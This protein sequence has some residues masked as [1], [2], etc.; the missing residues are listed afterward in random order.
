MAVKKNSFP[1]NL[2]AASALLAA[3]VLAMVLAG[4]LPAVRGADNDQDKTK[5][6]TEASGETTQVTLTPEAVKR[7]GIALGRAK[8]QKLISHIIAPA[9]V[10]F[11]TN[12]MAVVGCPVQGRVT[13]LKVSVG[14]TVKKG[15]ELLIVESPELGEA[16]SDYLQK[17]TGVVAATATVDPLKAALDRANALYVT[18]GITLTEVQKRDLDYKTAQNA[19]LTAKAAVKAAESRLKLLGMDKEAVARLEETGEITPQFTVRAPLDGTVTERLVT[20]GELVK[21]DREKLLVVADMTTLWVIADVPEARI[22]EVKSGEKVSIAI[23]DQSFDG[24]VSKVGLSVDPSTRSVP[25]Q[26][27]VKSD[28]ALKPGMFAEADI[29]VS[30]GNDPVVAVPS[31]AIQSVDGSTAVFLPVD[32]RPNTFARRMVSVGDSAGGMLSIISGLAA[33][34]QIV[35]SG[36]F[37]LKAEL[38]KASAKDDD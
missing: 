37:I 32:G 12:A 34:E 28:P 35:I 7:Y 24:I 30:D 18:Q 27:E 14:D 13:E 16:Q 17:R 15:D 5:P 20:L 21:P 10:S 2:P 4:E 26:I 38:G 36:T 8:K 1:F 9:Q 22:F 31:S 11:N 23:G 19:A 25:V 3:T 29:K 33:G 6:T